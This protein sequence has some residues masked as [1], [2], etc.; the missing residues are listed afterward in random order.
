LARGA[1]VWPGRTALV[2]GARRLS[3]AELDA[4]SSRLARVLAEAGCRPGDRVALALP[5][6]AEAI[7]GMIGTL[8]AGGCYVPIDP[9]SPAAR[10][11]KILDA[12]APVVI[13]A[14]RRTVELVARAT[15]GRETSGRIPVGWL[16]DA[17]AAA[18]SGGDFTAADVASRSD[19][20]PDVA[21]RPEATAHVLF[22]SGS[23]GTPKGVAITHAS[24]A[25]FVEWANGYFRVGPGE[26]LS[27]HSPLFFD[28]STYDVYGAFHAGAELHLV[29][30]ELNLLPHKL[31]AFIRERELTQ[32]FSVPSILC[33]LAR[34]DAVAQDDFP[35]LRRLLWC[36]EVFATPQLRYWMKRLP[37][38]QF[39]NLYGPTEATIA[40]SYHTLTACPA[41]DREEIPIGRACDGEQLLVLDA[42]LRPVPPGV[43]GDLY[44]RG[45]GLSP[46][47]WNDPAKTA[48][49][50]LPAPDEPAER[51]YRT[52]DLA[53]VGDDGLVYY[54]GRVDSQI[55]SRGFRIELGEIDAALSTLT[56][57]LR[58]AAVVALPTDGFEGHAICCAYVPAS[59][60]VT[61]VVLRK[62]L[63]QILPSYMIPSRFRAY[64]SLP[65][66]PNGKTDRRRLRDEFSE[67]A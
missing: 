29:A 22:T 67:G 49:V 62:A 66:T 32:W 64:E 15:E 63:Q 25:R 51:I 2:D 17:A 24:V 55:K 54:L 59:A 38:V 13:L 35:S 58:E 41:H 26:R 34:F 50:F 12:C 20:P 36:G 43:Q 44:I 10:V 16:D 23:T 47:Y 39:T 40:S 65:R 37:H 45:A 48:E 61:P 33:Y 21:V 14:G 5:K 7:V 9:A 18:P 52:G 3:Y 53:R 6:S 56:R 30:P 28:L 46:G 60:A 31:V 4:W 42:A 11:R 19:V 27:G 8:K 57:E 1:R